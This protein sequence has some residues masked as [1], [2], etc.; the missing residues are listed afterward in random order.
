V[1][2]GAGTTPFVAYLN[3]VF[4]HG[5]FPH[6]AGSTDEQRIRDGLARDLLP[7]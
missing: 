2:V 3:Q 6:P 4:A 5:G 1:F 7:L